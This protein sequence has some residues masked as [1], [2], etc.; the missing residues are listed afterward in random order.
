MNN[1]HTVTSFPVSV[2]TLLSFIS[3]GAVAFHA[4]A[5]GLALGVAAPKAPGLGQ[6]TVLLVCLH[7]SPWSQG[8]AVAR[9]IFG[10]TDSFHI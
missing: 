5:E 2:H 9:C 1:L 6:H 4:L 10:A 7:G 3:C 8:A